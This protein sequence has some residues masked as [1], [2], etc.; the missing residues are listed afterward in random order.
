MFFKVATLAQL[1]EFDEIIDVRSPS[2]FAE[3]HIPGASSCPVLDDD[4]RARVGTLYCQQSPFAARRV[5]AALVARNIAHHIESRFHDRPKSWRPLI[6]CWRGGQRSAAMALVLGQVGWAA[7]QLEKGYK[8]YRQQVLADLDRLPADIDF[9]VLTGPTGSGKSRLLDALAYQG[10]Q[11]LDLERLACHR[12]SVLGQVPGQT[13]PS[14][15]AFE[16]GLCQ[17]LAAFDPAQPV[18]VEAESR[19]IGRLTL[20]NALL[21]A[22]HCAPSI[23]LVVPLPERVRFLLQD[24]AFLTENPA[25]LQQQLDRLKTLYPREQWETWH[26]LIQAGRYA[27]LVQVLLE[28]HY[29]P[30]YLRA[31]GKHFTVETRTLSLADI[32]ES[33]LGH[34]ASML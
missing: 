30:L 6:Y 32:G 12:G 17:A 18:Y 23:R 26:A 2:E 25:L 7:H 27:E 21:A 31:T 34:A 3:D 8:G 16:T 4:E 22:M 11:V 10:R 9:R 28:R 24:Y 19:H 20:P 1:G 5:G 14:Q 15:K 29:D 33:A 13:Q